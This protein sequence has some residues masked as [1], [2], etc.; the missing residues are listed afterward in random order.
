[1]DAGQ[2]PNLVNIPRLS[3]GGS[4]ARFLGPTKQKVWGSLIAALLLV[5]GICVGSHFSATFFGVYISGPVWVVFGAAAC[6]LFAD[7]RTLRD[8]T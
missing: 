4:R 6:F 5:L 7:R 1:M 8:S 2:P 3:T